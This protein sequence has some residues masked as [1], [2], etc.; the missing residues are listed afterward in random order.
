MSDRIDRTERLLNLVIC[1]MATS[2][3][4]SRAQIQ[5][6]IPGYAESASENSSSLGKIKRQKI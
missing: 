6:D 5:R 2:H 3:A 1:L 4:V